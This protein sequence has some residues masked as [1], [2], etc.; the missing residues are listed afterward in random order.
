MGRDHNRIQL[1]HYAGPG[2][3][4]PRMQPVDTPYVRRHVARLVAEL[5]LRPGERV[6]DVGCGLG[7]FTRLLRDV[8]DVRV[9]GFDLS[10]DLLAR[11]RTERPDIPVHRGDLLRPPVELAG[12]FDAVT[13]FFMLHHLED[14]PTAFAGVQAMLRPGGRAAFLEPNAWCPLFW[15]QVTCAPGLTWRAE[16]G[17]LRMTR[18]RLVEGLREAGFEQVRHRTSGLLPPQLANRA[19]G[20]AVDDAVD[21]LDLLAPVRAFAVV[22]GRRPATG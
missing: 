7:K 14:L 8:H 4:S 13:G 1:E 10:P 16:R 11:L 21:D 20:P 12:Q 18:R 15:L 3:V 17:I 6:L 2:L 19:R 5:D 22:S 9:E